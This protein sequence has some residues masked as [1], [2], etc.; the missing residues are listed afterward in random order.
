MLISIIIPIYNVEKYL[1]KCLESIVNQSYKNIELV[2]VNDGSTD[3]SGLICDDFAKN[4]NRIKVIHQKNAR[5]AAARN[6]GFRITTGELIWFIDSD[7]WIEPGA[8][9]AIFRAMNN[10]QLDMIGFSYRYYYHD[11]QTFS[12]PQKCQT[13]ETCSAIDYIKTETFLSPLIWSFVYRRTF[14]TANNL[15]FNESILHED[16]AFNLECFSKLIKIKKIDKSLYNYRQ[17]ENSF[18]SS[19]PTH[20]RLESFAV[21][22][23]MCQNYKNHEFEELFLTKKIY[24]LISILFTFLVKFEY[25]AKFKTKI[26][27]EISQL[28]KSQKINP[29]DAYGIKIEKYIYNINPKLYLLLKACRK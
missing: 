10:N 7:D 24:N 9:D 12:A 16:E 28:V 27:N 15:I 11:N 18:M 8:I 22:I 21:L 2:L 1:H 17:R 19:K 29:E 25:D 13:I 14:L 5:M 4:D 20:L 23:K 26:I 6:A 3:N